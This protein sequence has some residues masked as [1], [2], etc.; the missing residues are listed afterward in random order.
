[1]LTDKNK[2]VKLTNL[3]KEIIQLQGDKAELMKNYK[4][5]I[6]ENLKLTNLNE[7]LEAKVLEKERELKVLKSEKD[8]YDL[9]KEKIELKSQKHDI[10]IQKINLANEKQ[11]IV[12]KDPSYSYS[13]QTDSFGSSWSI[14]LDASYVRPEKLNLTKER[15]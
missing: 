11:L 3:E 10:E 7:R 4:E 8:K 14:I 6:E 2:E 12:G 1:M 9:E 13:S 15:L 5:S